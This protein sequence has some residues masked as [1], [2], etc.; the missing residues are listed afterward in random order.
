MLIFTMTADTLVNK[1]VKLFYN[2]SLADALENCNKED[3]QVLSM[4]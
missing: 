1:E 3:Y 2:G 4:S